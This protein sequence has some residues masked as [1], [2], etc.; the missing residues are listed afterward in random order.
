ML[1]SLCNLAIQINQILK[2]KLS[3][4]E[5]ILKQNR[6]I[7]VAGGFINQMMGNNSSIPVVGKGCTILH[8]SDRSAYEVIEVSNDGMNCVI[9]E[10]DSKFIGSGY[11]DE[12]YTYKSNVENEIKT[13]EY[14][15]KK[16]CWGEI[17]H[18]V[19]IIKSLAKNY[20]NKYGYGSTEFLLKDN[21]IKSYEHLYENPNADND[22][23]QMMVINGVTK[24]YKN[25]TKVSCIFGKMEKYRDPSF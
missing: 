7:G 10:M 23:N 20:F 1:K 13:L 21:G 9:R 19:E 6:K 22:Y 12:R 16:Q 18:T 2:I 14:S 11:G 8:Y 15:N 4:M 24:K 25:F 17:T 3:N 5:T